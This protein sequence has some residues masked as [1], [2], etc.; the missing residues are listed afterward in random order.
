[1][2]EILERSRNTLEARTGTPYNDLYYEAA[3]HASVTPGHVAEIQTALTQAN[4]RIQ[5]V[6]ST[7]LADQD[8]RRDMLVQR[9][10]MAIQALALY[11]EGSYAETWET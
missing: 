6:T 9:A 1:M 3:R 2:A 7:S 11:D 8:E 10:Q 5:G 4:I